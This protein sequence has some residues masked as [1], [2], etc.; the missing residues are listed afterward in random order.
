MHVS[1]GCVHCLDGALPNMFLYHRTFKT[2][3]TFIILYIGNLPSYPYTNT[4]HEDWP[5][6]A[7]EGPRA[8]P[9]ARAGEGPRAQP[10]ASAGE[11]PRAQ[12]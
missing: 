10:C 5:E 8:Q 3:T 2:Q 4:L 6:P 12:P 9:C 7:V 1:P 11:G